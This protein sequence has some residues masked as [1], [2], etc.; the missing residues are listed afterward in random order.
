[1]GGSRTT[2]RV[3][4]VYG[5]DSLS[6]LDE[7]GEL[8]TV[9][10]CGIQAPKYNSK[11]PSASEAY[12]YFAREFLRKKLAGHRIQLEIIKELQANPRRVIA[13]AFIAKAY[14]NEEVLLAGWGTVIDT[15]VSQYT[16]KY[17]SQLRGSLDLS[18][19]TEE[20]VLNVARLS[21]QQESP[22]SNETR[23]V[24]AQLKAKFI[25]HSGMHAGNERFSLAPVMVDTPVS[26]L[27]T[28]YKGQE[29]LGSIEHVKDADYF[30]TM[31]QLEE[32]PLTCIKIPCKPFGIMAASESGPLTSCAQEAQEHAVN[33]LSGKT[34]R[35]TPMLSSGNSLSCKVTVCTS[36]AEDK[37]Y[38]HALL[39]KGYAKTVGWMLD[40]D[41]SVAKL[42]NKA[43][44]IARSKCLG[45]WKNSDQETVSK[46][47]SA[48][49]LKK[50]KQYNGT[51]I[52][53]PSS[54]SIVIRLADGS[55]LRAWFS[56]LLT[57]RCIISKNSSEVEEAG[58][59]LREYLRKNY[60]GRHVVAKLDYLR[61][62]PQP[63]ED[64]SSR[65][66][67]SIYLQETESNIALDLIKNTSCRVVRHPV[68]E[69]NRS[70]DYALML[71]AE[72]ENQ[73]EKNQ[74]SNAQTTK[75]M[76]KV[77]DYSSFAG[78]NNAQIQ[79]L[80]REHN[81]CYQA[82][83]DSVL[84]GS[85]FKIYMSNMRGFLQVALITL[86]G[87]M[88]PSV[89]RREAFSMEALGYAK[90]ILLMKDIKV[91]FTGV[92]EKHT[93]ALFARVSFVCKDGQEK[94]FSG[95]LLENGFGELVK[96]KAA[97]E[98]GL[99][100]AHLHKYAALESEAKKKRVGLFKY[101]IDYK[102][103]I[104][105]SPGSWTFPEKHEI[106]GLQFL[107]DGT[108]VF[109]LKGSE[110]ITI[111]KEMLDK[112]G[113][114]ALCEESTIFVK[115]IVIYYDK[116]TDEYW[117]A[118]IESLPPSAN[119]K[120]Q[121]ENRN[122][123]HIRLLDIGRDVFLDDI[124][125]LYA[126]VPNEL[127]VLKPTTAMAKLAL[128]QYPRK[129]AADKN[130]ADQEFFDYVRRSVVG[131]DLICYSCGYDRDG[132][133]NVFLFT[134]DTES[135]EI[136]EP[137]EPPIDVGASITGK[138]IS[139]GLAKLISD[140]DIPNNADMY[141]EILMDIEKEAFHSRKGLWK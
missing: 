100:P 41:T 67:F 12:G 87:V 29:L 26:Q 34:V 71:E 85:R 52:D 18:S 22:K 30:I 128:L 43:E 97:S 102:E 117:R 119:D 90:S 56:S 127:L 139:N 14:I 74:E 15:Y 73:A 66:Y 79:N 120:E 40:T 33:L 96:G 28:Q 3:R 70:R 20:E 31:V 38:A 24:E 140:E 132:L 134:E 68:A 60:V 63:K 91:T 17:L 32:N 46:E 109:R 110:E 108:F 59:H 27:L 112:A 84:S 6:V 92:V 101:Y 62:P 124:S 9:V 88:T 64:L 80:A 65:P 78:T 113:A 61:D 82:V 25:K 44:E 39:S 86:A 94:D 123:V 57:P 133:M 118:R 75:R 106:H 16:K 99:S 36:G 136:E 4:A 5:A 111:T 125:N 77:I 37:D 47:I 137:N 135:I 76:L 114:K 104:V 48:G 122:C 93:N 42:Y 130:L 69:T 89:K 115:Q 121:H 19:L 1:M 53:V 55:S 7:K 107:D 131:V 10:L 72:S 2:V 83:V 141:Y 116:D 11:D 105:S 8:M 58:F 50:N 81:G 51:V 49:D 35:L 95:S 23:L 138:V 98:S 103:S 126:P 129:G 45:V 13:H 54:D 21:E